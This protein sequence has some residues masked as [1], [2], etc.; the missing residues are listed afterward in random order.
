MKWIEKIINIDDYQIQCLW[1][2]GIT[3]TVDLKRF[4]SEKSGN[5]A[6]SYSI[7]KDINYF[8]KA[9]CDGN[10]IYWEN[11]IQF[12]DIDGK[13]KPGPLDISPEVLYE[14]SEKMNLS[15]ELKNEF[16]A[17]DKLSDEAMI[18]FEEE[19]EKG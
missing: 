11:G 1:N 9:K 14:M 19:L 18:K 17:W 2:D 8:K 7:L 4:I 12:T 16:A 10:S 6:N 15:Y 13:L 3:R 5:G